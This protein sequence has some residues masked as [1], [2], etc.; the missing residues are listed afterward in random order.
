[1]RQADER[2][3]DVLVLAGGS[4]V[5]LA[6]DG[7]R[8]TVV[9]VRTTGLAS[10]PGPGGSVLVEIAAGEGWDGVVAAAVEGGLAGIEC[11]SGIPG[12]AGATPIQNV[13]AYGQEIA[14]T[15]DAV[16]VLDR[17]SGEV[18][19]LGPGELGLGYRQSR[20]KGRDTHVVLGVR[21]RLE[22]TGESAPIR[23]AELAR[24]L[25]VEPGERVPLA[26]VREAVL[27]LRRGK[28]MVLDP[29]D[30]DTVSA[31]SFFTNPVLAADDFARLE[32]R[33]AERLGPD[34]RPPAFPDADGH[35]KT[36]AAWLIEH[37]GFHRGHARGRVAIS[38]KHTLALTNR[39]GASAA[40]LVE[41]AAEIAGGVRDAFGVELHP[42]P[43]FPGHRWP[44]PG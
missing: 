2:G 41:L 7:W 13:G 26:A 36:S 21:L 12:S 19:E 17:G 23:Y 3:E 6:D 16:R 27:R 1:V 35:V 33:A 5:V 34:A 30:P 11:L 44:G 37:A 14:S 29:G 39:G 31:G 38:S 40:E 18:S 42:E 22:R 43:V 25:G 15:L 32:A 24:A 4:N 28:G 8:G 10:H 20:F 9:L